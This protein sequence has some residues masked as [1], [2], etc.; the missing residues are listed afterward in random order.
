MIGTQT[1]VEISTVIIF[2]LS[3]ILAAYLTLNY[4]QNRR[5]SSLFW[6]AGIWVFAISVLFETLFAFGQ[7]NRLLIDS[8]L[9]LVALLVNLLALCSIELIKSYL[10]KLSYYVFSVASLS[11]LAY[12]L[13]STNV[14]NL[15]ITYVVAGLTPVFVTITSS[16]VVFPAAV[17]LVII[18]VLSYRKTHSYKMLSIIAGVVVVSIAGTLY[19]AA[20]PALLYYS[21]LIGIVLLWFGFFNFSAGRPKSR[22]TRK[23]GAK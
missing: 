1:T 20:F 13:I 10:L 9:F 17:I 19:I 11:L 16:I 12:S 23:I 2:V 7:Y 14:G 18:A 5:R 6:S 22:A 8:F 4:M 3:A 21:E 15:M